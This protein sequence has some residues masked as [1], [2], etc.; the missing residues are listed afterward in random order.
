[1]RRWSNRGGRTSVLAIPMRCSF[2]PGSPCFHTLDHRPPLFSPFLLPCSLACDGQFPPLSP[3]L[4]CGSLHTPAH[5]FAPLV[6]GARPSHRCLE[7]C[8]MCSLRLFIGPATLTFP[9]LDSTRLSFP[10]HLDLS[11]PCF[12]L[13][14]SLCISLSRFQH[15]ISDPTFH[16]SQPHPFASVQLRHVVILPAN[17]LLPQNHQCAVVCEGG[18]GVRDIRRAGGGDSGAR[19]ARLLRGA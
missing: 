1:M 11:L 7:R 17:L 19:V 3:F 8:W 12:L 14:L 6:Q 9:G 4:C 15:C 2:H 18:W 13:S 16:R 5:L 10:F